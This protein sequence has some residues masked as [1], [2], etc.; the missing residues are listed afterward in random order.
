MAKSPGTT[1]TTAPPSVTEVPAQPTKLSQEARI[2]VEARRS[3]GGAGVF[4]SDLRNVTFDQ[5]IITTRHKIVENQIVEIEQTE[6]AAESKP[7][8]M[9]VTRQQMETEAKNRT[10]E[11]KRNKTD[12]LR[13]LQ[14]AQSICNH[15]FDTTRRC[16]YCSKSRNSHV[17]DEKN[18]SILK[19]L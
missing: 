10:V 1:P 8:N 2:T 15:K 14:K 4:T 3:T 17:Y 19:K 6:E 13:A 11:N 16:I 7:S 9:A 12:T 5:A 18:K